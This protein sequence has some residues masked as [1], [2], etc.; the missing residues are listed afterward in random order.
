MSNTINNRVIT[1]LVVHCSATPASRDI[2]AKEIDRMHR[3]RGFLKIGYHYVIKRDGTVE[4]GRQESEV[5][6][7]V[8][9]HNKNSIG[10]CLIGGVAADGKTAERNYTPNQY[11][12]LAALLYG[13]KGRYR[14][15][16]ILGHRDLSPDRNGDGKI[17]SNE[18]LKQCP[19]FDVREWV[20][21]TGVLS[22]S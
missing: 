11:G 12:S 15:A 5:G 9:G 21:G 1:H 4:I 14:K 18:W 19:C 6:A 8:T 20:V 2:G 13:L 17:T 7:H 16:E 3:E 10:I 22:A